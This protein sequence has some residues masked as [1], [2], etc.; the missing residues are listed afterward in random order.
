V[1]AYTSRRCE[2]VAA[3]SRAARGWEEGAS[4]GAA[5]SQLPRLGPE[6]AA[7]LRQRCGVFG[8]GRGQEERN[9]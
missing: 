9:K 5:A 3:C 4:G 6:R 7:H 1:L 2:T 8:G